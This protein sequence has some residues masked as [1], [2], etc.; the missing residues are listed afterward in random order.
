MQIK[1][2]IQIEN[3]AARL[4]FF[5]PLGLSQGFGGFCATRNSREIRVAQQ[6]VNHRRKVGGEKIA[7][8]AGGLPRV[9]SSTVEFV[10]F[11]MIDLSSLDAATGE[12]LAIGV[13][14][15]STGPTW[16]DA[17]DVD[18]ED[19][20]AVAPRLKPVNIVLEV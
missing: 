7:G 11:R 19:E 3:H 2:A 5:S 14:V 17:H 13:N 20:G 15:D 18:V 6:P 16:D 12:L 1:T 4:C 10:G 8:A 9:G